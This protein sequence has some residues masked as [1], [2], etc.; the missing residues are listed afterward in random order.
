MIR[1]SF[2]ILIIAGAL[3][4]GTGLMYAATPLPNS[5]LTAWE[6]RS[7][8]ISGPDSKPGFVT[9]ELPPG[10]FAH[11]KSDISD[12]RVVKDGIP[13]PY[14]VAV[15]REQK[16]IA[17][18]STRMFNLSSLSGQYT[19]FIVDLGEEGMLHNAVTIETLSENYRRRVQVEGSSDSRSWRMLNATG[20]IYDYT[21]RDIKPVSVHDTTVSYPAAAFRYLRVT[22]QDSGENPLLV[23]GA[24]VTREIAESAREI[25]YKPAY[26]VTENQ[27]DHTTDI[28]L[29]LGGAGIPHRRGRIATANTNFHRAVEIAQSKDKEKWQ[30]LSHEYLFAV[31]TPRFT[32][33]HLDFSYP[34]SSARYLRISILNHDDAPIAVSD[35]TVS[36]VVRSILFSYDPASRYDLY[37]GNSR[38]ERPI[39]DIEK[40][41]E[42]LE[43]GTLSKVAIGH[44]QANP[45]YVPIVPPP[46]PLTERAPF[47]LPVLLAAIVAV[48]G[49]L[50]WRIVAAAHK[51][52]GA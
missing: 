49:F 23:K 2:F 30:F 32:G 15:E 38:A 40:I 5:S 36:G 7:T 46:L 34:E 45:A 16:N 22:I 35:V 48:L 13:V 28:I 25:T 19:S 20:Q 39:Y 4:T 17:R 1:N 10:F 9:L 26:T 43:R 41:S 50:I 51:S 29:D 3:T 12:L 6:F 33:Q 44:I 8:V 14:V 47:L 52:T 21:V 37:M 24:G 31:D 27:K 11:L 42:Y 18:V